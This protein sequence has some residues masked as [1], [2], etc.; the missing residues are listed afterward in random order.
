VEVAEG[1]ADGEYQDDQ[2]LASPLFRDGR[3]GLLLEEGNPC[4]AN[5]W[6]QRLDA[7]WSL[8]P[9]VYVDYH[10]LLASQC[11]LIRDIFGNPFRAVAL[12]PSWLTSTVV[13]LADGIYAER[14]FDRLPILADALQDAGC[15][16]GDVLDHCRGPGPHAR[17]CW[18]VDL[19]LGKS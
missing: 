4:E 5:D 7:I 19:L 16:T 6:G 3:R 14:A 15:D 12:E 13:A 18:V 10:G 1:W 8:Y 11:D 2:V 9:D 17:G